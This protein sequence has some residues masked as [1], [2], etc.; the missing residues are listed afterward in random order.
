MTP[1]ALR[2]L[3]RALDA[4]ADRLGRL[5]ALLEVAADSTPEAET[6]EPVPHPARG[7]LRTLRCSGCGCVYR[8]SWVWPGHETHCGACAAAGLRGQKR[9]TC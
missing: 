7:S 3:S 5:A 6:P 9:G 8:P 1:R 2:R 4:V